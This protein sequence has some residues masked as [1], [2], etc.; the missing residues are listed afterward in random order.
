MKITWRVI[1]IIIIFYSLKKKENKKEAEPTGMKEMNHI[2][3]NFCRL[4]L[5]R[6]GGGL[7]VSTVKS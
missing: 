1:I 2:S 5:Q 3:N 6:G 4:T 7:R